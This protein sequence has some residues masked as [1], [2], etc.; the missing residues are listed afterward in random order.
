MAQVLSLT[1]TQAQTIK[2]A[3]R[4]LTLQGGANY[5]Y[6]M[7]DE[8]RARQDMEGTQLAHEM[9]YNINCQIDRHDRDYTHHS[10]QA[11][12]T[13]LANLVISLDPYSLGR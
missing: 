4:F 8:S 1:A 3:E 12:D 7:I 13:E 9:L 5:A 11:W 6:A 10:G 2:N